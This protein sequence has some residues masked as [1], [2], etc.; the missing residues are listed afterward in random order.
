MCI[1]D[2]SCAFAKTKEKLIAKIRKACLK[3]VEFISFEFIYHTIPNV[4]SSAKL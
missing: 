4:K 1:R 2:S 3:K